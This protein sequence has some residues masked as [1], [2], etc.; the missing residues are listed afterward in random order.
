MATSVDGRN[1]DL[2][3]VSDRSDILRDIEAD[4]EGLPIRDGQSRARSFDTK[5][6]CFVSA[7]VHPGE[8]TASHVHIGMLEFLLIGDLIT[9]ALSRKYVFLFVLMIN[10]AG[11][12]SVERWLGKEW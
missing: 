11:L 6:Y 7:R 4:Y 1:I 8:V 5:P 10:P 2:I 9:A 3:T 12:G